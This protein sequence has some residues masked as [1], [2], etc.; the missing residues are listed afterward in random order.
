MCQISDLVSSDP[1]FCSEVLAIANSAAIPH[2][3]PVTSILQGVALLGTQN[4]KGLCLTVAVR[5]YLGKSIAHAILRD[6]W[7]HCLATGL[8]AQQ[9]VLVGVIDNDTAYTA[10]LLHEMGR[11]ALGVVSPEEYGRLLETHHGSPESILRL[12]SEMF[13]FDHRELGQHLAAEWGLPAELG[14]VLSRKIPFGRS[15]S[16]LNL[17]GLVDMSSRMADAA[18]FPAFRG[19]EKAPYQELLKELS[20]LERNRFYSDISDLAFTIGK[21]ISLID[22]L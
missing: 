5:G 17:A 19:C 7:V 21:Q 11:L 3:F 1:A 14:E 16:R 4:L 2:R 10:G 22:A 8:I 13:G 15:D 20:V 12:E 9:L 18:G 6:I